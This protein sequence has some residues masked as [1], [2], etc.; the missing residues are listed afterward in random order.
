MP[1]RRRS[2][3][4]FYRRLNKLIVAMA[5]SLAWLGATGAIAGLVFYVLKAFATP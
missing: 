4:R 2:S 3:R 1:Y 5:F